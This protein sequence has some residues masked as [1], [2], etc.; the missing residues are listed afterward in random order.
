VMA[1]VS[2]GFRY[3]RRNLPYIDHFRI[4]AVMCVTFILLHAEA[5]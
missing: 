4:W 5:S 2:V 3:M 1:L